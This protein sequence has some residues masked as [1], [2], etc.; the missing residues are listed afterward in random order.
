MPLP[1]PSRKPKLLK[2][3]LRNK[4]V[5]FFRKIYTIF[6]EAFLRFAIFVDTA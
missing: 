4:E 3:N 2:K 6:G 1:K 5:S